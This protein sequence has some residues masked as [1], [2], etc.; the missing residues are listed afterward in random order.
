M[1]YVLKA[2]EELARHLPPRATAIIT[3]WPVGIP[4]LKSPGAKARVAAALRNIAS[5]LETQAKREAGCTVE[6]PTRVHEGVTFTRKAETE[7][8]VIDP[9]VVEQRLPREKYPE[10]WKVKR[11]GG[12]VSI[13]VGPHPDEQEERK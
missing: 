12:N 4:K 8:W 2:A 6:E 1:A 10:A 5:R 3:G 11:S 7:Q 13:E 9:T